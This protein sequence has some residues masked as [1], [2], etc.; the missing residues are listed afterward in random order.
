M[1]LNKIPRVVLYQAR[2]SWASI[3]E[4]EQYRPGLPLPLPILHLAGAI[5]DLNVEAY[6][7]QE[8]G[9]S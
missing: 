1:N 8:I 6:L 7:Y 9:K 5:Q 4:Y 2:P 3:E